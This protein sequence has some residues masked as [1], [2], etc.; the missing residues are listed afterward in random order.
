MDCHT[1][2]YALKLRKMADEHKSDLLIL[3]RVY[4]EKPRTTVGEYYFPRGNVP[5]SARVAIVTINVPVYNS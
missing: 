2:E 4:F 1:Q 5:V 3:M